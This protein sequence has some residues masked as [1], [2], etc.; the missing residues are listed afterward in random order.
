MADDFILNSLS[1]MDPY[2]REER[3]RKTI[4]TLLRAIVVRIVAGVLLEVAVVRV[5]AS[6][7]ALGLTG[8]ALLLILAGLFPLMMELKKQK[9]ILIECLNQQKEQEQTGHS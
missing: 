3:C 2:D 7:L 1:D 6:S 4:R 9:G 5:G 8:F